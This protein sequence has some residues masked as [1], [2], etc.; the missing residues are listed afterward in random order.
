M[1]LH[2]NDSGSLD[3]LIVLFVVNRWNSVEPD[4][5]ARPFASHDEVIPF[6]RLEGFLDFVLVA[7]NQELLSARLVV[8][9]TPNATSFHVPHVALIANHLM[10]IRNPFRS[11]LYSSVCSVPC[12]L[13]L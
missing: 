3:F 6:A 2:R 12:Q 4:L 5:N 8:Q 9:R 13:R 1:N 7:M 10:M 11:E